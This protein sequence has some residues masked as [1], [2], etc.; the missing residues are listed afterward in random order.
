[1][2]S[3]GARS[4]YNRYGNF[5]SYNDYSRRTATTNR[6]Y[7]ARYNYT[8][9]AF[10]YANETVTP[11]TKNKKKKVV[12][13]RVKEAAPL[14]LLKTY[15]TIA[16]IFCFV[17]TLLCVYAS[18]SAMRTDLV[19]LQDRLVQTK[20]DNEY[21]EVSIEENLDLDKIQSEAMKLGL[22]MPAEYQIV[23]I[24]VPKDSYTVQYEAETGGKEE[25]FW[26]FLKN[27]F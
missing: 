26:S 1:M 9:E 17:L 27:I 10:D 15:G 14:S 11:P 4:N 22:Q 8:S 19:E 24:N 6:R 23:E 3:N 2:K 18:N 12:Y 20:E 7:N 5:V 25:G 16:V 21:I 13:S